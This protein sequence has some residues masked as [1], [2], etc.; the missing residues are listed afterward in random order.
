[1][2]IFAFRGDSK[3]PEVYEWTTK[4]DFFVYLDKEQGMGIG[5]GVKYGIFMNRNLEKGSSAPTKTFGNTERLSLN[6][7]FHID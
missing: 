7:D 6:E 1:M 3:D 4:N 2:F 5:M